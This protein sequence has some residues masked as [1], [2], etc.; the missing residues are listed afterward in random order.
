MG[1]VE[2]LESRIKQLSRQS[3]LSRREIIALH[4]DMTVR[5]HLLY[6]MCRYINQ[7]RVSSRKYVRSGAGRKGRD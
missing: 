4:H 1:Y 2:E 3:Q 7:H 6:S 5:D